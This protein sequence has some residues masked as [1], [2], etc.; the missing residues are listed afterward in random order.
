MK[1]LVKTGNIEKTHL[2]QAINRVPA[3]FALKF[4]FNCKYD[5]F[6]KY[7]IFLIERGIDFLD[8]PKSRRTHI[9]FSKNAKNARRTHIFFEKRKKSAYIFS[10]HFS[11]KHPKIEFKYENSLKDFLDKITTGNVEKIVRIHTTDKTI[12][13]YIIKYKLTVNGQREKSY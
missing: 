8:E 5:K 10:I 11:Q 4:K 2:I 13:R 6:T 3:Q 12:A 7:Q 1:K 9:L